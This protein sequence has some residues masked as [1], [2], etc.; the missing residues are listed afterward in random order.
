MKC[1][2]ISAKPL[3]F[4]SDSEHLPL[5]QPVTEKFTISNNH[6]DVSATFQLQP[7]HRPYVLDLTFEPETGKIKGRSA[8]EVTAT[9]TMKCT[10]RLT[11]Q[12]FVQLNSKNKNG[13]LIWMHPLE[14]E[15]ESR[16]STKLDWNEI[17]VKEVLGQGASCTVNNGLWRNQR[18]AIKIIKNVEG[19][20]FALR[21]LEKRSRTDGN[22]SAPKYCA[23]FWRGA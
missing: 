18:V 19:D 21:D 23:S 7:L 13:P 11:G 17:Q 4:G 1:I 20:P 16:F 10:T 9:I 2:D 22:I 6:P 14:V 8:I 5:E 15:V 12:L 3:R